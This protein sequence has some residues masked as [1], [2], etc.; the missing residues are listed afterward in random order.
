MIV[1]SCAG[2]EFTSCTTLGGS[3]N[4]ELTTTKFLIMNYWDRGLENGV[5]YV[6]TC[7]RVFSKVCNHCANQG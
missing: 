5:S 1:L 6:D 7:N 3:S 4:G 2:N